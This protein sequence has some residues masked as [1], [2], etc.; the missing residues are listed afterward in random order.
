M[1]NLQN[2]SLKIAFATVSASLFSTA[3]TMVYFVKA[4][5]THK[6][7]LC[8]QRQ[9]ASAQKGQ[10]VFECLAILGLVTDVVVE[11]CLLTFSFVGNEGT[12]LC[13]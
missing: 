6:M 12:F 4:S 1:P 11:V 10:H 8:W 9:Q 2:H 7:Y 5:V 3:V 13:A